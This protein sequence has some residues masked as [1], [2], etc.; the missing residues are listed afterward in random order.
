[1]DEALVKTA[2]SHVL[3]PTWVYRNHAY[4]LPE[5]RHVPVHS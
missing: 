3:W 4:T 5:L 1:V 2:L